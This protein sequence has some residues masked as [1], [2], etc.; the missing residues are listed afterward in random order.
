MTSQREAELLESVP[1]G[2]LING[3]WR[4]A[5]DGG[6]FDVLDPAT[7]K[8]LAT[9]ASATSEDAKAALDAADAVQASWARTS[10]RERSEILRRGFELIQERAEDFALLMTLEMGK[11]LNEAMGEVKYGNEFMRWFSEEAVRHNGR[12]NATPE[13]NMKMI[14]QHKPVGPCLLITPWNFCLLYTS[15]AADDIALV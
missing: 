2:L 6:T 9:L 3:E 1:K 11:P 10:A 4:D 13:G 5:S 12:Y 7:G 14:V 8:V 15:D